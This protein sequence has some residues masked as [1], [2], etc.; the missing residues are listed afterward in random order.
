M[1]RRYLSKMRGEAKAPPPVSISEII[2]SSL[3][4]FIGIGA[5]LWLSSSFFEPRELVLVTGVIGASAVLVFGAIRSPFAQP[6]S[7]LGGHLLS[8]LIGVVSWK[9]LGDTIW[10]A[11]AMAVSLSVAGMLA[12]STVHPPGGGTALLA[13]IGGARI[14]NLGFSYLIL[15]IGASALILFVIALL[16]NNL[17]RHRKYPEYWL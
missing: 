2:W 17:S 9:L 4:S 5:C 13:V 10:L 1:I 3:G 6:R 8:A 12:T 16:F 15:P 14:H 7:L 11:S